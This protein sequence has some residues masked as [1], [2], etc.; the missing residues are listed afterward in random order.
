LLTVCVLFCVSVVISDVFGNIFDCG[1]D[2]S[3]A[4]DIWMS[5][6]EVEFARVN[7]IV[8]FDELGKCVQVELAI[9]VVFSG[10]MYV[11]GRSE[12]FKV[13]AQCTWRDVA[14]L[15]VCEEGV[16]CIE[17]KVWCCGHGP[18]QLRGRV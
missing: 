14:G 5:S 6:F 12:L 3:R 1:G 10:N 8:L 15:W 16:L 13:F 7:G 11:D 17:A 2:I 18:T 9:L 4:D